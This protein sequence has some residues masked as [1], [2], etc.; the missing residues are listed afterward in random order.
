MAAKLFIHPSPVDRAVSWLLGSGIQHLKGQEKFRG[1][2]AAWYELDE[3]RYPFLYS[4]IT[5]YALTAFLFLHRL[6]PRKELIRGASLAARW[7]LRHAFNKDGGVKTRLYLAKD[8]VS[9]NYSFDQGR[10][11]AFDAAMVGY[12]LL[13]F[14]KVSG[15]EAYRKAFERS[16]EFLVCR[17]RKKDGTFYPYFDPRSGR[18][19]EDFEKWSDQG[20]SFHAKLALF[21]IDAYRLTK[22]EAYRRYALQLLDAARKTQM[23]DGR[24]ITGKKDGSTH[25]HPHAYTLEGLLYGG[26]HL[27]R[28]EYVD[29]ALRGLEWTFG[30]VSADGSVSSLY[31][32]GTFS[33]HERSDIVAQVLRIA[34]ILYA[35]RPRELQSRL[36]IL[37][38]I[39]NHLLLFQYHGDT[40]Q[41]GGFLY[42]SATD[43]LL[44][45]HLNSWATMFAVQG[46]WMHEEF[47]VRRKPL[48]LNCLI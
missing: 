23:R 21:L 36:L 3:R 29:A 44:R 43:G 33:H 12:G 38:R 15:E 6:K 13:Q 24:F 7:L 16:L 25:L 11:Y 39:K 47:V 32:G 41:T 14:F 27:G 37:E 34:S 17:M 31:G 5:G 2:V 4:E 19:G 1:G 22:E 8:Y 45:A 10:V 26:V 28:K 9:P 46:L 30:G 20:G 40:N 48:Q 42:G 35:L 18:C